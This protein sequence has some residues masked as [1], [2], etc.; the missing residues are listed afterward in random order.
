MILKLGEKEQRTT[1]LLHEAHQ[2]ERLELE[3]FK[4]EQRL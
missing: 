1:E 3:K 4:A 2:K